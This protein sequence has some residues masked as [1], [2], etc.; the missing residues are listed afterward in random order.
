MPQLKIN[1]MFIIVRSE[2][3]FK[4]HLVQLPDNFKINKKFKHITEGI[5]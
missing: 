3:T 5:I 1:K 4:N 2:G